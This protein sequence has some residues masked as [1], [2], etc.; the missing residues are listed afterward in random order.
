MSKERIVIHK[1]FIVDIEKEE[2][3][4]DSYRKK[5]Y[6]LQYVN[7]NT[8]KYIF[9][10]C[11]DAFI[12]KVRIDYRTFSKK[13]EYNDYLTMYEDAGWKHIRGSKNSGVH[14]FEQ[15][16]PNTTEELFSDKQSYAELYKRLFGYSISGLSLC[17]IM[18]CILQT[19]FNTTLF[20]NPKKLFFTPGLWDLNGSKFACAFLFELPFVIFRNI[21]PFL[22]I[23][24]LIL[25]IVC[26]IKCKKKQKQYQASL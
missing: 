4:I 3:F 22:I 2:H 26:A 12:P 1:I 13:E 10:K 11:Q 25:F 20:T 14:Y 15:M 6:K 16:T 9:T 19:Q 23:I 8:F 18:L 17:V 21:W 7:N 24:A 5:G